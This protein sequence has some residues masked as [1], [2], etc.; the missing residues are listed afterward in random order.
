M[1]AELD[2]YVRL[3]E[4]T[5]DREQEVLGDARAIARANDVE[6]LEVDAEGTVV[7]VDRDGQEVLSDLV[8]TYKATS[9]EVAAFI[10]ARRVENV[11]DDMEREVTLPEN[12]RQHL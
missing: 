7:S 4:A 1:E 12:L 5:I 11:V 3:V 6:G 2:G 9:G 10:I 8:E